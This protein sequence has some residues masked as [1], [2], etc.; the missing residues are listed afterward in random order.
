MEWTTGETVVDDRDERTARRIA[1]DTM[2]DAL[3]IDPRNET[4]RGAAILSALLQR[5]SMYVV[6]NQLI[7]N[8]HPTTD[9]QITTSIRN[10]F[11]H[12]G[13]KGTRKKCA[14]QDAMDAVLVACSFGSD[15]ATKA[16]TAAPLARGYIVEDDELDDDVDCD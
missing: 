2:E 5:Q 1:S 9:A 16:P 15:P 13:T 12:H 14:E 7:N 11:A 4:A 10:F 6:S 3:R 8:V